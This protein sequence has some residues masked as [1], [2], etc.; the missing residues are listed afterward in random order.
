M[1]A[2]I[3]RFPMWHKA[4]AISN[5]QT[6][7]K[8]SR[9]ICGTKS[10]KRGSEMSGNAALDELEKMATAPPGPMSDLLNLVGLESA[11]LDFTQLATLDLPERKRHLPW[12]PEGGNIMIYGP[13]GVGI[14]FLQLG[15]SA[16]LVTGTPFLR[17]QTQDPVGVLYI[18]GEMPLDE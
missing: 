7:L 3:V 18:D 4:I 2:S 13:R 1:P 6:S 12:L 5:G 17:W 16:A 8:V 10:A 15:V 9:M 14:T 11:L